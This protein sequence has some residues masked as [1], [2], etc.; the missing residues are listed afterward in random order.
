V[1]GT[2]PGAVPQ[3]GVRTAALICLL[4]ACDAGVKPEPPTPAPAKHEE[5][6]AAIVGPNLAYL[7]ADSDM[8]IH[9]DV[10]ALR[11]GK[12]W[13]T[14]ESRVANL[15][16]P[17]FGC[18]Y[19]PVREVAT[20]EIGVTIKTGLG[21]FVVRGIDRNKT[22]ECLHK[23][24]GAHFDGDFVT[25]THG[26]ATDVLTFVDATTMLLQKGKQPTKATL[27]QVVHDG[28]APLRTDQAYAAA[29]KRLP[30]HANV[31]TV[32]RPNSEEMQS[33]WKQ[34]GIQFRYFY[35]SMDVTEVGLQLQFAMVLGTADQATQLTTLMQAQLKSAQVNQLFDRFEVAAN[36]DTTNMK[37]GINETK[38]ASLVRMIDGMLPYQTGL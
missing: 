7:A 29:I 12:L 34:M 27:T 36:G 19:A 24:S 16:L 30:P 21:V 32:S 26:G 1:T 8:I 25:V 3:P 38:L 22:L 37:I 2:R 20:V 13:P 31:T 15:M 35:G 33:K 4:V 5:A 28:N 11:Q 6:P 17:N 10:A 23:S 14:Y 9:V 18:D